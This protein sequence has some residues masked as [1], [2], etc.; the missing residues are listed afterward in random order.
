MTGRVILAITPHPDDESYTVGGVLAKAVSEG[1]TAQVLCATRGEGGEIRRPG[2]ATPESL[3]EVRAR[4][5]AGACSALGAQPPHFLGYRDGTLSMLDLGEAVGRVV[6]VIRAVRPDVVVT[7]GPDGVYGHPDHIALHKIVTPAFRAAGG[8]ARFPE[9]EFGP[10]HAP[11]RLFWAAYPRGHFLPV[12]ERLLG[13]DL[14]EG[15][16][17]L[18]PERLGAGDSEIDAVVD[19]RRWREQKLRA[20]AAHETQ[21]EPDDPLSIFPAGVLAPVIDTERFTLAEGERPGH[22]LTDLFEGLG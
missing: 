18:N 19:V 14:A 2:L 1:H 8:G 10:P 4:E 13:T 22:R 15:V 7:L 6:R 21:T 11:A 20:M 16:R 17:A 5:L 9:A 12:W 3:G